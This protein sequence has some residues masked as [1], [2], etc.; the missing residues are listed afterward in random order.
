M[1]RLFDSKMTV[2]TKYKAICFVEIIRSISHSPDGFFFIGGYEITTRQ[3]QSEVY[4]KV[5]QW[6]IIC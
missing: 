3:K 2:R 6:C 4:L 5:D 1:Q